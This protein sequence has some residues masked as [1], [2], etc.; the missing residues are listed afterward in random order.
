MSKL[1]VVAASRATQ[2]SEGESVFAKN[3]DFKLWAVL[4]AR[5]PVVQKAGSTSVGGRFLRLETR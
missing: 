3:Y 1:Q 5:L 4:L 2:G